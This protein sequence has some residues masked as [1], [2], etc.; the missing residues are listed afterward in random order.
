LL[1]FALCDSNLKGM[2]LQS[3]FSSTIEIFESDYFGKQI[4]AQYFRC[5]FY[6]SH[7]PTANTNKEIQSY[8]N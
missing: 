4:D 2:I 1:L 5:R 7:R 8:L 3:F 6:L